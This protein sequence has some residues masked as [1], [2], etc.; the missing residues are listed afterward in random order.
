MSGETSTLFL[1]YQWLLYIQPV[2]SEVITAH[3]GIRVTLNA[4]K[5]ESRLSKWAA[6]KDTVLKAH[7]TEQNVGENYPR[8]YLLC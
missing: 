8:S 5:K 3:A 1:D 6:V 4:I 7:F 2:M